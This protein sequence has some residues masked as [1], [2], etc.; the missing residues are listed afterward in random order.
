MTDWLQQWAACDR[1]RRPCALVTVIAAAGS[2][3]REPGARMLVLGDGSQ[4]GTVGGG[5]LELRALGEAREA[6]R[7]GTARRVRLPLSAEGQCCGGLVELLVEPFGR[8][9]TLHL[10]GAG[11]VGRALCE[12]LAGTAIAVEAV[13]PRREGLA[14]EALPAGVRRHWSTGLDY[15][16]TVS[17]DGPRDFALVMTPDHGEDLELVDALLQRRPAWIGLIGS[18]AKWES[19][20]REL[21]ERG[22]SETDLERVRCPVGDKRLGKAPREVAI[23]VAAELLGELHRREEPA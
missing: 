19:F 21:R 23:G 6:L 12:T 15:L 9:A 8:G 17:V 3:P 11:H 7:D 10:F 13:D 20:R 2:T 5:A 1:E 14:A 22:R 4:V 16:A 18:R